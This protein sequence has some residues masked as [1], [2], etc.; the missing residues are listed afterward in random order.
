M[1]A[2]SEQANLPRLLQE[3]CTT[4]HE[5]QSDAGPSHAEPLAWE[6]VHIEGVHEMRV[7]TRRIRAALRV[8]SNV[9]PDDGACF[10]VAAGRKDPKA[11]GT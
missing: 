3:A 4:C 7:A 5:R 9:L 10:E 1:A 11:S 6:A 8:F 2:D